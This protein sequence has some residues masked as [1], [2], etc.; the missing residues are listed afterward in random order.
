VAKQIADTYGYDQVVIF[1]RK[2][3]PGGGEHMTTYGTTREHC[4]IAAMI[5][6]FLKFKIMG[7]IKE[8]EDAQPSRGKKHSS[9]AVL[10]AVNPHDTTVIARPA[11][12]KP[13]HPRDKKS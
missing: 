2:V 12:E 11:A 8:A 5:G 10:D 3:G 7:W 1:T 13:Q 4:R 6:A 9:S